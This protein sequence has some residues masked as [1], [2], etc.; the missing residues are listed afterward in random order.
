M[1]KTAT[2]AA[3]T[4][5][6]RAATRSAAPQNI[7]SKKGKAQNN[8]NNTRNRRN[9]GMSTARGRTF[10]RRTRQGG[11]LYAIL[12]W[13]WSAATAFILIFYAINASEINW[14][15]VGIIFFGSIILFAILTTPLRRRRRARRAEFFQEQS[16]Q[17]E[18]MHNMN[19]QPHQSPEEFAASLQGLPFGEQ[20]K[21]VVAAAAG[22][23]VAGAP[24]SMVTPPPVPPAHTAPPQPPQPQAAAPVSNTCDG[25]GAPRASTPYCEYCGSK[26]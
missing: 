12:G 14:I 19:P 25:C 11:I 17:A 22:V 5:A 6:P 15:V 20:A 16:W 2:K 3:A 7:A 24:A 10:R 23:P 1:T 18:H 26:L 13:L 4:S 21:R 8:H 9:V